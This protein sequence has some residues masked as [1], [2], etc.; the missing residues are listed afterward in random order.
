MNYYNEWYKVTTI[1]DNA[2]LNK[3]ALKTLK[4]S[5]NIRSIGSRAFKNCV[6]LSGVTI[7]KNVRRINKEA[8]YNCK[9][10]VSLKIISMYL[11]KKN[12]GANAFKKTKIKKVNVPKKKKKAYK[13][14]LR[15]RGVSRKAKYK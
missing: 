4:L 12:V 13:A 2:C 14:L 11:N 15:T 9:K 7:S 1:D 3:K 8:F 5:N 10:M 6:N